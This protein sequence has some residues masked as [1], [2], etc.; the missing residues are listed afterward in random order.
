MLDHPGPGIEPMFP[1][2]VGEF[3]TTGPPGK[4]ESTISWFVV[5]G[6]RWTIVYMSDSQTSDLRIKVY[7]LYASK[8]YFEAYSLCS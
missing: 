4:L 2:L 3:L 1:A 6:E 8:L 7:T 5:G